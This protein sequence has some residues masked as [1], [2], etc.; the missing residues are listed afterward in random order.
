MSPRL[1]YLYQEVPLSFRSNENLQNEDK[2]VFIE[3]VQLQISETIY[4]HIQEVTDHY[5]YRMSWLISI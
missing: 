2:I 4:F 1:A 5:I 3:A